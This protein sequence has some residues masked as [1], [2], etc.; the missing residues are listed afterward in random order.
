[1]DD[2]TAVECCGA[3]KNIIALGAG[4]V[5]ALGMGNNTKCAIIRLGLM[6][7]MAFAEE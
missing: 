7:M 6:E 1:M 5:D 3:L 4:F 2:V